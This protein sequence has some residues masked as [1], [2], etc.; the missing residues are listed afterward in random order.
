MKEIDLSYVTI[1]YEEPIVYFI[2]KE[3]AQLGFPEIRELIF[4]AE[5][6][7]HF[8]PYVTFSDVR[9]PEMGITNEGKRVVEDLEICLFLEG[10]PYW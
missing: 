6:L 5:K 10:L 9:A 2:Y 8:K 4:Y 1:K 7:S 3:G